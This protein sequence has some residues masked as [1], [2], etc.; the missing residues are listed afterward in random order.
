LTAYV[1]FESPG[2]VGEG[3]VYFLHYQTARWTPS[4]C[5]WTRFQ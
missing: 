3:L 2:E 5:M 4:W 1:T